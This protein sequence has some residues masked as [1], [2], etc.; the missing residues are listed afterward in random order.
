MSSL[1]EKYRPK[2]LDDLKGQPNALLI[3]ELAEHHVAPCY[4]FYGPPGT[5]KT[6]T[7][8]LL[9]SKIEPNF[10]QNTSDIVEVNCSLNGNVDDIKNVIYTKCQTMPRTLNRKYVILDECHMLS[11][12]AQ[13]SLL[14]IMEMPPPFLTFILCT[15]E[16][17]KLA[18]PNKSR[19]LQVK[20]LPAKQDDLVSVLKNVCEEEGIEHDQESLEIIA[21]LSSGSFREALMILSQYIAI[22]A[23]KNNVETYSGSITKN[24]VEQLIDRKSVV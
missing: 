17:R 12:T 3:C 11:A 13:A 14:N 19:C 21:Q 1:A 2:N 6:S 7:A 9:I 23:T 4:L 24:S 8:K 15:T 20:F 10:D 16:P 22:G 18:R 5:G